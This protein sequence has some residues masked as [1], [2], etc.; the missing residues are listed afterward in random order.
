MYTIYLKIESD[1]HYE[2]T[3]NVWIKGQ[4]RSIMDAIEIMFKIK[5]IAEKELSK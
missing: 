2:G 4:Y 1:S 3:A 5:E